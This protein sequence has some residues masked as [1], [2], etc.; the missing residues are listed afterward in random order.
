MIIGSSQMDGTYAVGKRLSVDPR[1]IALASDDILNP[2]P[3]AN[4]QAEQVRIRGLADDQCDTF[5]ENCQV[6]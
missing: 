3:V 6:R 2:N 1:L 5:N 4:R